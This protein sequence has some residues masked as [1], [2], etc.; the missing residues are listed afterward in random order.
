[1]LFKNTVYQDNQQYNI[2]PKSKETTY[3]LKKDSLTFQDVTKSMATFVDQCKTEIDM[4]CFNTTSYLNHDKAEYV[5]VEVE[6]L[7]FMKVNTLQC[8]NFTVLRFKGNLNLE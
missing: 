6:A 5:V 7:L 2:F 4:F 3:F 8:L 1:M